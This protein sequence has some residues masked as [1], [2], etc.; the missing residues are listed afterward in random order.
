MIRKIIL[1]IF[2]MMVVVTFAWPVQSVSAAQPS[3]IAAPARWLT[4]TSPNGGEVLSVGSV[5][6]ITWNSSANINMVA[7]GYMACSTCF[8]LI[9]I[10]IPNTGYYDWTVF[11]G[12][13]TNTQ[14]RILVIGYQT[15]AG[16]AADTSDSAFT[17]N[18][19]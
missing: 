7:I 9:A 14:Y 15:G 2:T 4:L 13:T 1:N 10:N 6:R 8:N 5:H 16:L 3:V 12:S 18:Q 11:V 19:L 17:V